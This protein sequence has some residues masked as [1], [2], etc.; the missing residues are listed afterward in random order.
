MAQHLGGLAAADP[1]PAIYAMLHDNYEV[2]PV[3]R[4]T[5]IGQYYELRPRPGS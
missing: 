3:F 5:L 2:P 4:N 1:A